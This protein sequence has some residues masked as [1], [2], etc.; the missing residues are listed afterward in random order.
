MSSESSCCD[1][2]T[3]K[4]PVHSAAAL[5]CANFVYALIVVGPYTVTTLACY[6]FLALG[7][8]GFVLSRVQSSEDGKFEIFS[9][10]FVS[11]TLQDA[12]STANEKASCLRNILLWKDGMKS[13]KVF[14][15]VYAVSYVSSLLTFSCLAFI[16]LWGA[17]FKAP[18]Q[19]V[20]KQQG[21]AAV[22]PHVDQVSKI[23]S[24]TMEKIP[25]YTHS[26]PE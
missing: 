14:G 13:L 7:L 3:W 25:R 9:Q 16:A 23:W 17:F 6:G 19:A 18:A 20:W 2:L 22:K 12:Y 21:E 26:K 15:V 11:Q 5:I 1:L 4:N 8:L 10:K 24:T